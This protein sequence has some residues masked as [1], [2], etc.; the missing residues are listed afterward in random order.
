[1]IGQTAIGMVAQGL[2]AF[3]QP[4]L[5]V[6]GL[7]DVAG[8]ISHIE[9][10]NA[11]TGNT[12]RDVGVSADIAYLEANDRLVAPSV[13]VIPGK[14]ESIDASDMKY[15]A[16]ITTCTVHVVSIVR[17]YRV[18]DFG[19]A[20]TDTL[21]GQRLALKKH[22]LEFKSPG[23]DTRLRHVRGQPVRY[24]DELMIYIDDYNADF[25]FQKPISTLQ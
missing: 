21:L 18:S 8:L 20:N 2:W 14:E 22:V 10:H 5:F 24:T 1:M 7:F 16:Q 6:P 19:A 9:A 12:W 11:A 13:W 17:N 23:F 3:A 4:L 25:L 15:I